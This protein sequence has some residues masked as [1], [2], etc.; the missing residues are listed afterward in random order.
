MK[1]KTLFSLLLI[2]LLSLFAIPAFSQQTPS[3]TDVITAFLPPQEL[4]QKIMWFAMIVGVVVRIVFNTYKGIT[5]DFN[6]SPMSFSFVYWL[7]DNIL[8]KL[9]H[10]LFFIGAAKVQFNFTLPNNI[11]LNIGLSL[12]GFLIGIWLDAILDLLK[13]VNPKRSDQVPSK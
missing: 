12:I 2:A 3:L 9:V 10:V 8:P 13:R 7:K 6:G 11:W 1:T 4:W 5:D